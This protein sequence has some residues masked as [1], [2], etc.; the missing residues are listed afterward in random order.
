M[1]I[2]E[3]LVK[4]KSRYHSNKKCFGNGLPPNASLDSLMFEE[5]INYLGIMKL[6]FLCYTGKNVVPKPADEAQE[7]AEEG[8]G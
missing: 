2:P 7:A 1:I 5:L 4:L 6:V 3:S 8:A